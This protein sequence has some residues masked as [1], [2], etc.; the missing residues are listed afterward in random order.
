MTDDTKSLQYLVTAQKHTWM[1]RGTDWV[2]RWANDTIDRGEVPDARNAPPQVVE[3]G[4]AIVSRQIGTL[5]GDSCEAQAIDIYERDEIDRHILE[6]RILTRADDVA[7]GAM[8][9][10]RP[11]TVQLFERWFF[12]VR[13]ESIAASGVINHGI[14]RDRVFAG[15]SP[16][17]VVLRRTGYY[18]GVEVLNEMVRLLQET[19]D[20]VK[21]PLPDLM[22]DAGRSKLRMRARILAETSSRSKRVV[23]QLK[24][25]SQ[26]LEHAESRVAF[27]GQLERTRLD[28]TASAAVD[29]PEVDW[30]HVARPIEVGTDSVR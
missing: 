26:M 11:R 27:L 18:E 10:L 23:A 30:Q 2:Y 16:L 22:T 4:K 19:C 3:A 6:A 29:V 20:I 28:L 24:Y 1:S 13:A 7:I 12:S 25:W 8:S 15:P 17:G 9:G 5:Q 21:D 14:F